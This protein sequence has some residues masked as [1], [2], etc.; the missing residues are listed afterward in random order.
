M[1]AIRDALMQAAVKAGMPGKD[2]ACAANNAVRGLRETI[3]Q[4]V[5]ARNTFKGAEYVFDERHVDAMVAELEAA[6]E[7]GEH[8]LG[9]TT[10]RR[11]T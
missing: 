6:V 2:A 1:V 3:T 5:E 10:S 11:A 8:H 4:S 7:V 9:R